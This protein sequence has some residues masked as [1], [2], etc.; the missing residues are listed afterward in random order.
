[1]LL[2]SKKLTGILVNSYI[3]SVLD[4]VKLGASVLFVLKKYRSLHVGAQSL[5]P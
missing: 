5:D 1:M 2:S 4:G 3:S